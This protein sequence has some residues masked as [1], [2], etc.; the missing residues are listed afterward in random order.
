MATKKTR[1]N[2]SKKRKSPS[3]RKSKC[4]TKCRK[5]IIKR[6]KKSDTYKKYAKAFSIFGMKNM[7]DDEVNK[8]K[9]SDEITKNII[10]KDCMNK[11]TKK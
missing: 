9:N 5:D 11:C 8:M 3:A 2:Y 7:Y 1:K 4:D 6:V 10:Y